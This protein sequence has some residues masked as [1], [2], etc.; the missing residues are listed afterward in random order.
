MRGTGSMRRVWMFSSLAAAVLSFYPA[1][2]GYTSWVVPAIPFGL[3]L[4]FEDHLQSRRVQIIAWVVDDVQDGDRPGAANPRRQF[5]QWRR[6]LR[7]ALFDPFRGLVFRVG[8]KNHRSTP[9]RWPRSART[10]ISRP[11]SDSGFHV[12]S[13]RIPTMDGHPR[14]HGTRPRGGRGR[15]QRAVTRG[16]RDHAAVDGDRA[17][18]RRGEC[19]VCVGEGGAGSGGVRGAD[20]D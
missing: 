8:R 20:S 12:P 5:V 17:V 1:W 6:D 7:P 14:G 2:I 15:A 19:R 11:N 10:R 9:G 18:G 13:S 4:V 3:F 16:G